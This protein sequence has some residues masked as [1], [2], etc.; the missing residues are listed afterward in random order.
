MRRSTLTVVAQATLVSVLVAGVAVFVA[1]QKSVVI[2]VDGEQRTVHAYA[3]TVADLL[4]HEGLEVADRDVV[5]PSMDTRVSSGSYVSVGRAK[6][7]DVTVDGQTRTVW[8]TA[9]DTDEALTQLGLRATDAYVA[10][11]RSGR[12]PLQG[13]GVTVRTPHRVTL[14]VDGKRTVHTTTAADVAQVLRETR[15]PLRKDD[16]ISPAPTSY[17]LDGTTITVSR[18]SGK[19]VVQ[20]VAI[21]FTTVRRPDP[22]L[23]KGQ[24]V[25]RRPGD[26]GLVV[27]TYDVTYVNG[28]L[29]ERRLLKSTKKDTPNRKVVAYGTR[30]VPAG[31]VVDIPSSG[32]L[33]WAALAQ[34]ESG[35]RPRAIGGG[36]L[37][38]GL[39]QFDLQT[40]RGQGGTGNPIDA[41]PAEQTMRAKSLYSQRGRA[42]WPVCGR[43]L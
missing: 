22:N 23:Y 14:L 5:V 6:Q 15:V 36:G 33:N 32:G 1:M 12:L 25:V 31:G 9:A 18:V 28:K 16:I 27:R 3:R 42:P 13:V 10:V 2:S 35:G 37:Y 38:F 41:S 19:R 26:P 17:P 39:Y 43:L 20:Q 30:T 4:E 34:C 29:S 24:T 7:L 8:T 21:P 11:S 40:W